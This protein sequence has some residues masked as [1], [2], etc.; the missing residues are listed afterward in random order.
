MSEKVFGSQNVVAVSF[1]ED[2]ALTNLK[3][4]DSQGQL[5]LRA[6]AVVMRGDDGR[7]VVK[8]QIGE[9]SWEGTATGGI[10]SVSTESVSSLSVGP[11]SLLTQVVEQ[12]PE[13]VDSAMGRLGGT[14]LRRSV[15]DV[16]AEIAAADNAQRE[17]RKTARKELHEARQKQHKDVIDAKVAAL[18]GKL[19][20]H[21]QVASAS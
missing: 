11:A 12:S 9:D 4:L 8:Q 3:E 20:G 19:P 21:K 1:G 5:G 15:H 18:K 13:V 14:V 17:A 16:E 7:V 2:E 10:S 6:A